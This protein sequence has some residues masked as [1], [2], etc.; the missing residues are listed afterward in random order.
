MLF[1]IAGVTGHTGSVAAHT[2]LDQGHDVRVIVRDAA[3]GAAFAAR[4]ASVAVA[5]LGDAAALTEALKGADGA[6]L[7]VPPNFGAA[8][9]RA[10]QKATGDSIVSA[11][12]ASGLPHVVL[13]SSFAAQV[14]AGTGP[15]A[16]LHGVE[17]ALRAIPGTT[18]TLL[19]AG[20][21]MEN[22]LSNF[23]ALDQGLLPSFLPAELPLPLIASRDIGTVA[24]ELLA[25]GT[26][27]GTRIVELGGPERS[28][29]EIAA[30]I[31]G[32][33]GK[34]IHVHVA[35][36]QAMAATLASYGVPLQM[37]ELYAEMTGSIIDGVAVWEGIGRREGTTSVESFLAGVFAA[38]G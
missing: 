33:L 18:V 6:W 15:I 34:D 24:A 2:L 29:T 20:Y 28:T 21:F 8:D 38:K 32:L 31:S 25:G 27:A 26:P 17:A 1:A 22:L 9:F 16:A 12:R 19:R 35:P 14:P 11:V 10:Y 5:D 36:V 23:G 3:K 4:G 13:L 7:L 30:V 37:G